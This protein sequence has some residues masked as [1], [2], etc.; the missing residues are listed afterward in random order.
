MVE[1]GVCSR[2]RTGPADFAYGGVISHAVNRIAVAQLS[3]RHLLFGRCYGHGFSA[4]DGRDGDGDGDSFRDYCGGCDKRERRG[5][6]IL[7]D[8]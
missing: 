1:V 7:S 4:A 6:D 5:L 3:W 2:N 8:S